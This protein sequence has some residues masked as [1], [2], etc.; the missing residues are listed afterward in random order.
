[1]W[2]G[3]CPIRTEPIELAPTRYLK[4]C[5]RCV[6]KGQLFEVWLYRGA[7]EE[8]EPHEVERV[9]P[10][11]PKDLERKKMA[12]FRHQSQKDRA[13]FPGGSDRAS[14]GSGLKTETET[15]PRPTTNLACRSFTPLKVSSSG[16]K[17]KWTGK[18]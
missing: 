2:P 4:R 16:G 3:K 14:F 1:M 8:W 12:I 6:R 5:A 17:N 15:R 10:L 9:V 13:M 18:R 7:W 11:S